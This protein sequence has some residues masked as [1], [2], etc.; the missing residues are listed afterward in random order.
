MQ[1]RWAIVIFVYKKCIFSF[2]LYP[3]HEAM[4][5]ISMRWSYSYIIPNKTTIQ[6][7]QVISIQV[8][9]VRRR[10]KTVNGDH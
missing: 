4:P 8:Y 2:I 5:N 3:F 9:R 1:L 7:R 10:I 6:V